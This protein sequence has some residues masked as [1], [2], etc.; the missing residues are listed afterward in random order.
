MDSI[1]GEEYFTRELAE[2]IL[3]E[4]LAKRE[5]RVARLR[6]EVVGFFRLAL[7]GVFLVFAYVHLFAVKTGHRGQGLGTAMLNEA[8][9]LIRAERGY[10]DVK[11][12]FLLVGKIN[13]R[14]KRFYESQGYRR[15]AT[16]DDLFARGD[17][18]YL[19]MKELA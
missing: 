10:P 3:G 17:T 6:G 19:M 11:K 7:D 1:L 4:A 18:E 16:L 9:R 12:S 14:A 8:E 15:I 2:A 13:R 5:L